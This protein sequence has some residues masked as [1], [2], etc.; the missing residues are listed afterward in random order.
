MYCNLDLKNFKKTRTTEK[1]FTNVFTTVVAS[2]DTSFSDFG[3]GQIFEMNDLY[4][5]RLKEAILSCFRANFET[6]VC[7]EKNVSGRT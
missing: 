6:T 3:C 5:V 4:Q 7:G 2:S 1:N